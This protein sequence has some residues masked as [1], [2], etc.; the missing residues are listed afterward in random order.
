MLRRLSL[1]S[2]IL[3]PRTTPQRY[4]A[5]P[6]TKL[7]RA[8]NLEGNPYRYDFEVV[9]VESVNAFAL[10]AGKIFVTAPPDC[11]GVQ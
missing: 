8:D 9:D 6:G 5:N 2:I 1:W 4:I 10:P 7:V 11:H 3:Q